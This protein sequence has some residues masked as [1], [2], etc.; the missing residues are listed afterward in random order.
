MRGMD[1][2]HGSKRSPYFHGEIS[3]LCQSLRSFSPSLG[4]W[5]EKGTF[6]NSFLPFSTFSVLLLVECERGGAI[7]SGLKQ[8]PRKLTRD[9]SLANAPPLNLLPLSSL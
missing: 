8:R 7:P 5:F 4:E 9:R 2:T 3:E 6:T 1:P